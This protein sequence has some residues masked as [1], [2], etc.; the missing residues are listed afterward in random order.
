MEVVLLHNEKAGNSAWSR[1]ALVKLVRRAGF[2]PHYLP[3]RVAVEEPE[4]LK[5]GKFAIVAGG[6]GAIRKA[7]QAAAG[8]GI[9]LA[10]LP[11]G[12]AN[13]ISHSLGVIGKPEKIVAGWARKLR[14]IKF[15][16]GIAKGP[17][18]K[19][20]FVEGVGLGLISRT[21]AVLTDI[22]EV[23]VHEWRKAAH[24]LH[25][26]ACVATALA[27]EIHALPVTLKTDG[28]DRSG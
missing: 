15:A 3:I 22:D 1:K 20:R 19:R 23:S 25:R 28:K 9:P 21:I 12:T 18:G 10:P 8:R 7:V 26:D 11:L 2:E 5:Q 27:H 24:K 16:L 14:T 13:N 4:R 6:D 17:W